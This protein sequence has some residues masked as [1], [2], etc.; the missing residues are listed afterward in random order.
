MDVD[1]KIGTAE[2]LRK[3]SA[4]AGQGMFV[5]IIGPNGSGKST[6]I[7][8]MSRTLQPVAGKVIIAGK[9][10]R[11]YSHK[12]L[13]KLLGFVPQESTRTFDFVVNDILMM[14]RYPHQ[15]LLRPPGPQDREA[16]KKAM[17]LTGIS[18]L[19]ERSISTLSGGEWQRVLI[20][21]TLA[22]ETSLLLLDEPISQLDV[23]HQIEILTVLHNLTRQGS[24]V[25]CVI[26]DLNLASQYCDEII[27]LDQGTVFTIGT[28]HNVITPENI[29]A[30]FGLDVM[31][32][33][34]PVTG[35]L[36]LIP[37]YPERPGSNGG[38]KVHLIC[39]GGSGTG[40]MFALHAANCNVSTGILAMNDSDYST[41]IQ[42]GIPC[43][44]EP[45]FS[46]IT[47]ISRSLLAESISTADLIV[48]TPMPFGQVN[49]DNVRIMSECCDKPILFVA[50][51]VPRNVENYMSGEA[52][53]IFK[54]MI[55][56]GRVAMGTS[57]EVLGRCLGKDYGN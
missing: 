30:V 20:A 29:R 55:S 28:P 50:D 42:L 52:T 38:Q 14:G 17:E 56:D 47:D 21:R 49:L 54:R 35:K 53:E 22:Q 45:S 26:H 43:I 3:V 41:S 33:T 34:H 7:R 27:M 16:C 39:G 11:E 8:C 13:A 57:M 5:G 10:I 6:F 46:P 51:S 32:R 23:N 4:S 18:H 36:Y 15:K 12:E 1:V 19:S 9:E 24:T 25:I 37:I 44:A 40:I 31:I 48:F 2:I